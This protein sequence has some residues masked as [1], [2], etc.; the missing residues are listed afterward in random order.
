MTSIPEGQQAVSNSDI[1]AAFWDTLAEDD[2]NPDLLAMKALQEES[3]PEERAEVYKVKPSIGAC[4][5]K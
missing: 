3:T 1:P 5:F 2:S 4:T